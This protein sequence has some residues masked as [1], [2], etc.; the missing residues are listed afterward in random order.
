LMNCLNGCVS[1]PP[2]KPASSIFTRATRRQR[3]ANQDVRRASRLSRAERRATRTG[4]W[5]SL[6]VRGWCGPGESL[7]T[8][9]TPS[10][11]SNFCCCK[12]GSSD[13]AGGKSTLAYYE[14]P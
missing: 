9:K 10:G 5:Q 2:P 11:K 6:G 12:T 7:C 1:L 14:R 3:L 13:C 4:G 8:K